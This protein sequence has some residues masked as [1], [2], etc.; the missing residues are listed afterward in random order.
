MRMRDV[1]A[2]FLIF[3]LPRA[4]EMLRRPIPHKCFLFSFDVMKQF[5]FMH[6]VAV[7]A[8]FVQFAVGKEKD[9]EI[10]P[11]LK[12][13]AVALVLREREND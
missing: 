8:L 3:F 6:Y 12:L 13:I 10:Y 5:A 4:V 9:D 7:N 1:K 11:K 2:K